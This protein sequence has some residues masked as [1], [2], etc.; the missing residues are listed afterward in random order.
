MNKTFHRYNVDILFTTAQL[1]AE[2]DASQYAE[3]V[4]YD[5]HETPDT[6]NFSHLKAGIRP[7]NQPKGESTDGPHDDMFEESKQVLSAKAIQ[8]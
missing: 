1:P 7:T 4:V 8:S 3:N 6:E 2:Y 5:F